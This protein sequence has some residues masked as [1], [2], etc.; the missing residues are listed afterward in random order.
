MLIL[1]MGG[2]A[3]TPSHATHSATIATA[4]ES[5]EPMSEP[6]NSKSK[7]TRNNF[8]YILQQLVFSRNIFIGQNSASQKI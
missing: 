6:R 2:S 4:A 1:N 8:R 5:L 3:Q 7:S